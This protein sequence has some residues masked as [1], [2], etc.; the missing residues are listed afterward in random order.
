MPPDIKTLSGGYVAA[1]FDVTSPNRIGDEL[2]GSLSSL[3]D[4]MASLRGQ[5]SF[6]DEPATFE[7]V[8]HEEKER[9]A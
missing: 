1:W 7:A 2:A 6:E 3:I 9:N 8:L 5:L 4:G